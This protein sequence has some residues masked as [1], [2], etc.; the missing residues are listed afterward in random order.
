MRS[1][2]NEKMG[3]VERGGKI[4]HRKNASF[5]KIFARVEKETLFLRALLL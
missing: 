3:R 4:A 1:G 2:K 5:G